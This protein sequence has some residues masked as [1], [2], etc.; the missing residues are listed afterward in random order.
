MV[1]AACGGYEWAC[2][3]WLV[4][5]T[6]GRDESGDDELVE[7]VDVAQIHARSLPQLGVH[8]VQRRVQNE[9]HQVLLALHAPG[10]WRE[11]RLVHGHVRLADQTEEVAHDATFQGG[12]VGVLNCWLAESA[13]LVVSGVLSSVRRATSSR[14]GEWRMHWQPAAVGVNGDIRFAATELN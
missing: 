2:E 1:A 10:L 11:V 5:L 13:T 7:A 12:K 14:H 4:L 8:R 9:L 6:A 3:C